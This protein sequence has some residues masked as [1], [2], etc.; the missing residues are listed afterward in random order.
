V[1]NEVVVEPQRDW[2]D[3][4]AGGNAVPFD[5]TPGTSIAPNAAV[6][7]ADQWIEFL[8]N[9]GTPA[10]LTNF[11]LSFTDASGVAQTV[12]LGPGNLITSAGSPYVLIGAPGSIGRNSIVQLRDTA[13]AVVDEVDLSVVHAALGFA[14]GAANEA[15]A[16]TPDGFDTGAAGD[17]SRRPATIRKPN[18]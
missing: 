3:S 15:V 14:T 8:T 10:E 18:P 13:N 9:T 11:T 12:T 16:R 4:G 5:G 6:T 7:A 1:I 2:D 17:F